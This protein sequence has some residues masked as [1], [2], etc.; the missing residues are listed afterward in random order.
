[1]KPTDLAYERVSLRLLPPVT[2]P[3]MAKMEWVL[4]V[5]VPHL[6]DGQRKARL[7]AIHAPRRGIRL[8]AVTKL[9]IDDP[10]RLDTTPPVD[11]QFVQ[12]AMATGMESQVQ[13]FFWRMGV[14]DEIKRRGLGGEKPL[15][16]A[17]FCARLYRNQFE[18]DAWTKLNDASAEYRAI[19]DANLHRAL[20]RGKMRL[21][22]DQSDAIK[23]S[24]AGAYPF[25]ESLIEA[26]QKC[27]Q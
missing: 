14:E 2:I 17:W 4:V 20:K 7:V 6:L 15:L 11:G 3:S 5:P 18:V 9:A 25:S 21:T 8:E 23:K 1:L 26:A 22:R 19:R 27:V 10:V 16:L 24:V 12:I 13:G